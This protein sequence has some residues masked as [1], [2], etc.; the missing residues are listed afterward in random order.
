MWLLSESRMSC[1]LIIFSMSEEYLGSSEC[2]LWLIGYRRLSVFLKCGIAVVGRV[3]NHVFLD[4][5]NSY[6]NWW[7]GTLTLWTLLCFC[8]H[9]SIKHIKM[10]DCCAVCAEPLE[11]VAYGPCGHKE[12][13]FTCTARMRF[14]LNDKRC[15]ICKQDCPNVYVTKV[16]PPYH[17]MICCFTSNQAEELP[18]FKRGSVFIWLDTALL[19]V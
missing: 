13:C 3:V 14:V 15:C 1:V 6:D 17:S 19:L 16:C 12:V 11:W 4:G 8:R 18:P 10:E 9:S 2:L 7:I 5:R